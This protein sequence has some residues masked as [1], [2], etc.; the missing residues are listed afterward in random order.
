MT[1]L[2]Q[3]SEFSWCGV[4]HENMTSAADRV[5]CVECLQYAITSWSKRLGAAGA[6]LRELLDARER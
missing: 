1:C 2:K 3:S 4:R 6:R 5:D